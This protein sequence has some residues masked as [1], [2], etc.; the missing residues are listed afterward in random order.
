MLHI[1]HSE[2]LEDEPYN[3]IYSFIE[4]D[5]DQEASGGNGNK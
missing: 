3:I 1:W 5:E 4:S 2:A